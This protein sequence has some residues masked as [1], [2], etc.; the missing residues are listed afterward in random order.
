[1]NVYNPLSSMKRLESAGVARQHAEAIAFEIGDSKNDL[2]TN[3]TLSLKFDSLETKLETKMDA[4]LNRQL[5][6]MGVLI[7][8]LLTLATTVIGVLNSLK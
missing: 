2:V 7:A 3:E 4:A 1:M 8:A 5:V 6:R